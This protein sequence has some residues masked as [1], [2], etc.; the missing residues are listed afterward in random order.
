MAPR[1]PPL[2]LTILLAAA[3]WGAAA[4]W[5]RW[6]IDWSPLRGLAAAVGAAGAVICLLGVWSFRRAGTT[7][8]PTRPDGASALVARGIYRYS[9]N[10]MYLGF[11]LWLVA[12]GLWL[13]HLAALALGPAL[14]ALYLD[15]FQIGPE[16]RALEAK[17]GADYRAYKR[18]VRRWL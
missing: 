6:S 3:M 13:A 11:L 7:V 10:P 8:N 18:Q 9:R 14:L 15:R 4:A 2:A 1:L 12:W 5:P 17:F 16:E